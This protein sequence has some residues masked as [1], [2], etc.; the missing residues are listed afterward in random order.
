MLPNEQEK[1]A[2]DSEHRAS[3]EKRALEKVLRSCADRVKAA[4]DAAKRAREES[5][6]L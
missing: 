1:K 3:T 2:R 6:G 4:E 5:S